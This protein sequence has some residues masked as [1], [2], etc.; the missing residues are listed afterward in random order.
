MALKR[1]FFQTGWVVEDLRKA[2]RH[3]VESTRGGPFFFRESIKP[4]HV[5]YRGEPAA[6]EMNVAIAMIGGMQVELIQELSDGPS[7]FRDAFPTGTGGLHHIGGFSDDIDRDIVTYR[8]GGIAVATEG[9]VGGMRFVYFDTRASIGC[10]T[11]LLDRRHGASL[12]RRIRMATAAAESWDGTDPFRP[13]PSESE[14]L[15][16]EQTT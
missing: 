8:K 5:L 1:D 14:L 12:E 4:D 15:A 9:S 7:A 2:M 3:W 10:M 11:E 13:T 6:L 16:A